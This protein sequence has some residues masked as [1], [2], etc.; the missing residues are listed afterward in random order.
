MISASKGT[1]VTRRF[2]IQPEREMT[3]ILGLG[4]LVAVLVAVPAVSEGRYS[5]GAL[6]ELLACLATAMAAYFPVQCALASTFLLT[7]VALRDPTPG[8]GVFC[9]PI[10]IVALEMA[11]RQLL[12]I[13]VSIW[14]LILLFWWTA[15][16][17]RPNESMVF[18]IFFWTVLIVASNVAG[19]L[20][21]HYLDKSDRMLRDRLR[22]QRRGIARDLHDT[23]AHSLSLIV[24]RAEQARLRGEIDADDLYF[25]AATADRS[26]HDLR[27][28]MALLRSDE[29]E[30]SREIW[31]VE[32]I[33]EVLPDA[34][35]RLRN[36]G[37]IPIVNVEGD[38]DKLPLS[39][40]SALAKILHESTTNV[41]KHAA[42][43]TECTVMLEVNDD[44]AELIVTSVSRKGV[45]PKGSDGSK[46]PRMGVDGMRERVQA[47]GGEFT[48]GQSGLRW[49][50]QV[51]LPLR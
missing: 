23:V 22:D 44:D 12:R 47:L 25:I 35:T 29:A 51:W 10:I 6:L 39:A 45:A 49:V 43:G 13:L 46:T 24:M 11:G 34:H 33:Q 4:V 15:R 1:L 30:P 36:A 32:P 31:R 37:F 16:T 14:L 41:I 48:A 17:L 27:G 3:P 50:T 9:A 8:I 26:I 2:S 21:R 42:R 5:I 40:N 20:V 38:L 28:M 19:V 7:L 18:Y